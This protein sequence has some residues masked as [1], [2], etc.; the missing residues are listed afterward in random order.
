[1]KQIVVNKNQETIDVNCVSHNDIIQV[2][3]NGKL[4]G[5]VVKKNTF[6]LIYTG[7]NQFSSYNYKTLSSLIGDNPELT[8]YKTES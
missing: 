6:Y 8:F 7:V 5:F 4:I 3:E 1:M 2:Y